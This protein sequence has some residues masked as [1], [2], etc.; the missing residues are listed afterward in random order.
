MPTLLCGLVLSCERTRYH[1]CALI[2][3]WVGRFP[4][5]RGVLHRKIRYKSVHGLL[6]PATHRQVEFLSFDELRTVQ[7]IYI[8]VTLASNATPYST[9][10]AAKRVKRTA[11][12]C[13]RNL[14]YTARVFLPLITANTTNEIMIALLLTWRR[15]V[16][17][18]SFKPFSLCRVLLLHDF[19]DDTNGVCNEH[20]LSI[21][22]L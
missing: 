9:T 12:C 7:N 1:L 3:L 17:D 21:G 6:R 22:H 13:W 14:F 4:N 19:C 10:R 18:S 2:I 20:A 11:V 8:S 16:H 15:R 5:P